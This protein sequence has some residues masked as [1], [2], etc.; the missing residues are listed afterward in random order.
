MAQTRNEHDAKI[1]QTDR[2]SSTY[3]P[4]IPLRGHEMVAKRLILQRNTAAYYAQQK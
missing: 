1:L 2:P 4:L 3:T